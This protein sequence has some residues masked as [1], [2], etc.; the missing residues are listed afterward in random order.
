M[1]NRVDVAGAV[2]WNIV[3]EETLCGDAIEADPYSCLGARHIEF[4]SG[5]ERRLFVSAQDKKYVVV[6]DTANYI[7][8][9]PD[10]NFHQVESRSFHYFVALLTKM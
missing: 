7:G 1:M 8:D 9:T 10:L 3:V 2:E 6:E 5:K 4:T